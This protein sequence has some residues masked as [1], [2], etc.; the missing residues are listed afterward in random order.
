MNTSYLLFFL[1]ASDSGVCTGRRFRRWFSGRL[2]GR[3]GSPICEA[4]R[5]WERLRAGIRMKIGDGDAIVVG[6]DSERTISSEAV[7]RTGGL[8][9]IPLWNADDDADV[10]ASFE[11]V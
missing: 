6:N 3:G 11:G 5:E 9:D 2:G 7:G 8:E 1:M 4:D 10:D